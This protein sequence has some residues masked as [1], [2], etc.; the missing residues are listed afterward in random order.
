MTISD[1]TR[2]IL[3]VKA[4]GRCSICQVQLVTDGTGADDPSVFG[5]EAHIVARGQG[6]PR[7]GDVADVDG[8]ANLILLCSKHHKQVDDQVGYYSVGRLNGIKQMHEE[9]V[10]SLGNHMTPALSSMLPQEDIS[11]E[12]LRIERERQYDA[13]RP[14]LEGRF[15]RFEG[16]SLMRVCRIEVRITSPQPLMNIVV[17]LPY[18]DK[19]LAHGGS[20]FQARQFGSNTLHQ[21]GRW[22][23]CEGMVHLTSEPPVGKL[24]AT[25]KC[26]GEYGAVWEYVMLEIEFAGLQ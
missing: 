9:W 22:L 12:L 3:W 13:M 16:E 1:R 5:E 2:K 6:G 18:G 15:I 24:E 20:L 23:R 10:A 26:R 7:A 11:K 17:E 21:P 8:Y 14:K 4:G 19:R 25:A